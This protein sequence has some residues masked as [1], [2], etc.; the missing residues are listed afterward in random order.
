MKEVARD[1]V[2]SVA[3]AV[4]SRE[5]AVRAVRAVLRYFGGQLIYFPAYRESSKHLGQLRGVL[6]DE[7]GDAD[8]ERFIAAWTRFFGGG[9]MYMPLEHVAF[10]D[11][12]ADEIYRRYDGTMDKMAD[13]C[14]EFRTSYVQI[15]RLYHHGRGRVLTKQSDLFAAD[16]SQ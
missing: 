5:L 6:A 2:E 9:Q 7:I 14:R 1:M 16:D 3:Q 8:A 11:E 10:R 13:L 4:G 12:I 15:Y